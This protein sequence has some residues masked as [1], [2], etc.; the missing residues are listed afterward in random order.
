MHE[1]HNLS[2]SD[3]VEYMAKETVNILK[4]DDYV[5]FRAADH[6]EFE[7]LSYT[8]SKHG[9]TFSNLLTTKHAITMNSRNGL[10]V[11]FFQA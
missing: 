3:R 4:T 8:Q 1:N 11:R 7:H 9:S 6:S 10:A 5:Q 2:T